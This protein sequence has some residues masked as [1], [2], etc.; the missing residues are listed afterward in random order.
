MLDEL[1]RALLGR[2]ELRR[3]AGL[4]HHGIAGRLLGWRTHRL[5]HTL[6]VWSIVVA[7]APEDRTLR[8]A[9]LLHD[10]GHA[11]YSHALEGL[12]GVDHHAA[13]ESVLGG[14]LG[15]VVEASGHDLERVRRLVDGSEASPLRNREGILHADH[16]DSFVRGA[17]LRGRVAI[18]PEA[19]RTGVRA[20]G[21]HLAFAAEL[22][23][24]LVAAIADEAAFQLEPLDVGSEAWLTELVGTLVADGALDPA[25]LTSM[26]DADLDAR[27]LTHPGTRGAFEALLRSAGSWRAGAAEATDPT[28]TDGA[29]DR[30]WTRIKRARYLPVPR[31][32]GPEPD[33][34][35]VRLDAAYAP[36]RRDRT[37]VAR[38]AAVCG[39]SPG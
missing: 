23:E 5:E 21:A 26:S 27:L 4:H 17:R 24:A 9:A 36:Y 31:R 7:V 15:A 20:D 12:P 16:L 3:L 34:W 1:E 2:P 6:G 32:D 18:D 35:R 38:H 10:V 30:V 28:G 29:T 33:G 25:A 13:L 22:A 19:V 11:P 37:V 14:P 39:P 8:V